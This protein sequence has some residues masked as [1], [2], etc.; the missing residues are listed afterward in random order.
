VPDDD[1]PGAY[2]LAVEDSAGDVIGVTTLIPTTPEFSVATP[3]WRVRR[4]AVS[5]SPSATA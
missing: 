2:H 1:V 3:A 5:T 4:T